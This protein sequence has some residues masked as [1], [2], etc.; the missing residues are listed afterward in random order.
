MHRTD[1]KCAIKC[2]S[3]IYIA[4]NQQVATELAHEKLNE[5]IQLSKVYLL[6]NV[7]LLEDCVVFN[8]ALCI[9]A[10]SC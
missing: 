9:A 6:E 4:E 1:L 10:A 7:V 3:I 5:L 8:L 2:A